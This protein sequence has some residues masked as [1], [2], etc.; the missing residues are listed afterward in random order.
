[1]GWVQWKWDEQ[2]A[3]DDEDTEGWIQLNWDEHFADD[4]EDADG[5]GICNALGTPP[6]QV[7]PLPL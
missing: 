6:C 5:F 7:R 2:F 1:M 3:D 4:N